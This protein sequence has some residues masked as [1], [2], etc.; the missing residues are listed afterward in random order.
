MMLAQ[1]LYKEYESKIVLEETGDE[2]GIDGAPLYLFEI[3]ESQ[4]PMH[5]RLQYGDLS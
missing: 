1:K 5:I 4:K 2:D 3:P